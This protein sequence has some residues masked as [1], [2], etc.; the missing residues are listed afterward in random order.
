MHKLTLHDAPHPITIVTGLVVT[1]ASLLVVML[2]AR[3]GL[4]IACATTVEPTAPACD[5]SSPSRHP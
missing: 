2:I 1:A 4:K 5:A 3:H